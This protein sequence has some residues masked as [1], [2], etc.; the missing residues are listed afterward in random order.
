MLLQQ[1]NVG[2]GRGRAAPNA[3][4]EWASLTAI[5]PG[6]F[7]NISLNTL[8]DVLP[9]SWNMS[10]VAG[11]FIN[12]SGGVFASDF[13]A[14]GALSVH[15]SGH[16]A[17]PSAPLCAGAWNFDL[18]A[19]MWSGSNIPAAPLLDNNDHYDYY[20]ESNQTATLGHTTPPHT[21][22][23]LVYQPSSMG[24]GSKGSTWTHF[25][26]GF[27]LSN[28]AHRFDLSSATDPA[29]RAIA[30]IEM[31]GQ[32]GTYP[33]AASDYGR[34]GYWLLATNGNGP[35]A[36]IGFDKVAGEYPV[37]R[38]E[39]VGYNEY[40][41]HF[42]VHIPAPWDCLV[43][44]GPSGSGGVN[45]TI[46]VC[47]IVDDVP[48]N[49]FAVTKSGT[50]PGENGALVNN[51]GGVWSPTHQR[52]VAYEG[53]GS[54]DVHGLTPPSPADILSGTWAWTSQT[55]AGVSGTTPARPGTNP[56]NGYPYDENGQWGRFCY[57]PDLDIFLLAN[58]V[59]APV[60]AWRLAA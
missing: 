27:R 6:T 59:E 3:L 57:V 23:G 45:Q 26:P 15:G 24:G 13:S 58:G 46:Y 20:G 37:T 11:P 31:G 7:A 2:W 21:Y 50:Y 42:M 10:E 47:P 43:A 55:L 30:T 51:S 36:F 35:L 34:R 4:P 32:N 17:S 56:N 49:F 28:P 9:E 25:Y 60:Q 54:Y 12:W 38:F 5:P 18:S 16:L 33:M 14:L 1:P 44:F 48:T 53:L 39:A 52:I 40:G 19:R 22:G 41:G 8:L 29:E